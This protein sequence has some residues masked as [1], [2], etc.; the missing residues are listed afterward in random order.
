MNIKYTV[1]M[2]EP[3]T[4]YFRVVMRVD[5]LREGVQGGSVRLAMPVWT[6]GSYLVREFAR[7]VLELEATDGSGRT[8]S[9]ARRTPR[10]AGSSPRRGGLARGD[11]PGLRLQAR[12]QPELPRQ[13]TTR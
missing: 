13:Q 5:G 10:T 4:H 12:D 7:N 9:S 6:P 1:S 3:E 11:L 8:V 2:E